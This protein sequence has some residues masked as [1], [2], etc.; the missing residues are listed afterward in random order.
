MG[1]AAEGRSQLVA[2]VGLRWHADWRREEGMAVGAGDQQRGYC[3]EVG[4]QLARGWLAVAARAGYVL[5][6]D[7]DLGGSRARHRAGCQE[8]VRDVDDLVLAAGAGTGAEKPA[9]PGNARAGS[10]ATSA[11]SPAGNRSMHPASMPSQIAA[12][13][14]LA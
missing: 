5:P 10:L 12:R 2:G 8:A 1:T 13:D 4:G 9:G 6:V 11:S 3:E 7:G 14:S